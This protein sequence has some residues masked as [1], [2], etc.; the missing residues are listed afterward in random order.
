MTT[1][2]VIWF[3]GAIVSF[4]VLC[5]TERFGQMNYVEYALNALIL[6]FVWPVYLA[7]IARDLRR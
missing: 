3:L 6:V 1:V 5:W 7:C 2:L 4:A